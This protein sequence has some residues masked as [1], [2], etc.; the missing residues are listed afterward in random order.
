MTV[1]GDVGGLAAGGAGAVAILIG[2]NAPL[3]MDP[4][5]RA[6]YANNSQEFCKPVGESINSSSMY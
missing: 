4:A 3:V 1:P 6:T 2:P 5:W